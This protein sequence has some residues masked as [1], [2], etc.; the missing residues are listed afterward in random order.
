MPARNAFD[1]IEKPTAE[2][3]SGTNTTGSKAHERLK[4]QMNNLKRVNRANF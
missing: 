1:F 2:D 3:L 4:K